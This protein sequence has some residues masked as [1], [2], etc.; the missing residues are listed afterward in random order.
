MRRHGWLRQ[1]RHPTIRDGGSLGFSPDS[2]SFSRTNLTQ[3]LSNPGQD[4]EKDDGDG[5][6][7]YDIPRPRPEDVEQAGGWRF[8]TEEPEI[9]SRQDVHA[10]GEDE[11]KLN[12]EKGA[13]GPAEAGRQA[14]TTGEIDGRGDDRPMKPEKL[15]KAGV[16][17]AE[18]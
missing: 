6:Q 2:S 8:A 13:D 17:E 5:L 4:E 16:G 15:P 9:F 7:T 3:K 14:R 1:N 10:G 18:R 12:D 11:V